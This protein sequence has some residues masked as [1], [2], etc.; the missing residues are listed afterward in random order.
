MI[1]EGSNKAFDTILGL[2]IQMIQEGS[3]KALDTMS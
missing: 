1:Q 2:D 3:N